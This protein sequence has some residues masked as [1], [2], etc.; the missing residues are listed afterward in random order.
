MDQIKNTFPTQ[1]T[2]P[3]NLGADMTA[4]QTQQVSDVDAAQ[5]QLPKQTNPLSMFQAQ[6]P[7][8]PENTLQRFQFEQP[9][10]PKPGQPFKGMPSILDDEQNPVD[11]PFSKKKVKDVP[12]NFDEIHANWLKNRTPESNTEI[13]AAIQPVIDTAIQS[14]V[15]Q[16]ANQTART[17]AKLMALRALET[18]DPSKGNVRNHLLSQLQSL[19]RFAAQQQNIID[20]PEQVSL[21]YQALQEATNELRDKLGREPTDDELADHTGLSRRRIK[22]IRS[23]NQPVSEGMTHNETQEDGSDGNVASNVPGKDPGL[24]AWLDFVYDDLSNTD[25]LI[26]DMLLGR[27]GRKKASVQEIAKELGISPSAVSQ[28]AA[29]IQE[30]IDRRHEYDTI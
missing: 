22:K 17:Q 1:K 11:P 28:R 12:D 29:K 27:N 13:L 2:T 10:Q 16:N 23:F 4:T 21:D 6:Q 15:G 20:V 5:N 25:K 9:K 14:Y 24:D 19:R 26:M 7:K 8:A 3:I 30:M 18:Y